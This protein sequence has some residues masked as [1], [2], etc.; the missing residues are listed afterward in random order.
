MYDARAVRRGQ[1]ECR[2]LGHVERVID[3]HSAAFQG[4]TQG[5]AIDV[6]SGDKMGAPLRTNFMNRQQIGMIQRCSGARLIMKR[7]MHLFLVFEIGW[8]SI[9]DDVVYEI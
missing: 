2:L 7:E 1:G 9:V 6:L 4:R 8:C 5:F 3:L